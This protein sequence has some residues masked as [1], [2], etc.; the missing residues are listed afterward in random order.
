MSSGGLPVW[1]V[2]VIVFVVAVALNF[3]WEMLQARLYQMKAGGVPAWLHCLR[4]SL[5]DALLVLLILVLGAWIL[6]RVD[7]FRRPGWRGYTWML[8]SG[9]ILA[10]AVEWT[11]VH[12]LKRWSYKPAMPLLPGGEIGLVPIALMLIL[13]PAIFAVASRLAPK[14]HRRREE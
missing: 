9:A 2:F 4:A 3:P 10:V 12:A 14:Q 5:G 11:S 7:W 13:P 8:L 1:K 6:G